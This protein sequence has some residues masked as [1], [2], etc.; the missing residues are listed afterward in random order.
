MKK[1]LLLLFML[2]PSVVAQTYTGAITTNGST[3]GT[4]N[5]CVAAQ[6][7]Q[8][9][10]AVAVEV[11][12]T[13]TGTLSFEGTVSG[14][15]IVAVNCFAPSSTTAVTSTTAGGVWQC[16]V[17]GLSSFWLRGSAAISGSATVYIKTSP[18]SV[19]TSKSAGG[20]GISGLT[21]GTIPKA[22]TSTTITDSHSTDQSHQIVD[23]G[24]VVQHIEDV[25]GSMLTPV[26]SPTAA[27][28]AALA[29]SGTTN[30]NGAHS[31]LVSFSVGTCNTGL[32]E[33]YTNA[34]NSVAVTVSST[35]DINLS[36]L[37]VSTDARVAFVCVYESKAGT[38][39]PFFLVAQVAA[40][41]TTKVIA[42]AD[43]SFG[44]A[45]SAG[46]SGVGGIMTLDGGANT[47]A[48]LTVNAARIGLDCLDESGNWLGVGSGS[49]FPSGA[50]YL[51]DGLG[52]QLFLTSTATGGIVQLNFPKGGTGAT[53]AD[54]PVVYNHSGTFQNL[55]HTV[56]DACTLGT[57]CAVTLTGSSVFSSSS[58]YKCSAIDTTAA[59]AVKITYTSGSQFT[60]T[61]TGTDVL[62]YICIGN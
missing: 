43:G 31:F 59:N 22:A 14:A 1:M 50:F 29:G 55:A 35:H 41:V 33:T 20:G 42:L 15:T 47:T 36:G 37:P 60:L 48:C 3:C 9:A 5:A 52:N 62:N 23:S 21:A 46:Y 49:Y 4:T 7:P 57:S 25:S 34:P 16:S 51:V 56:I 45:L 39:T 61:G 38:T 32:N 17:T 10:G 19:G 54:V 24:G 28:S 12:G 44:A 8:N 30:T 26:T 18:A 6:L 40:G 13:W 2:A 11:S 53:I 27:I 58:S